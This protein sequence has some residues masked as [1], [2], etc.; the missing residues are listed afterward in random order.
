MH[1]LTLH[2]L[3]GICCDDDDF[4]THRANLPEEKL[5]QEDYKRALRINDTIC[6]VLFCAIVAVYAAGGLF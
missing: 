3:P 6:A 1:H 2:P 5:T 4:T